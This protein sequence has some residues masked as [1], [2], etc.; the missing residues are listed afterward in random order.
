[1]RAPIIAAYDPFVEDRAPVELALAAGD[2]TGARVEVVSVLPPYLVE[3]WDEPNTA[4]VLIASALDRVRR[5][6]G[7][8]VPTTVGDLSVPH[9]LHA[10]AGREGA[11]LLVVGSTQRGHAGRVLPGST[12]ERLLHGATCAVALAPHGY[13]RKPIETVAVGFT[14]S[15][16]GH[17]AVRTAHAIARRAGARLRVVAALHVSGVTDVVTTPGMP[18]QR[19]IALEG[20]RRA[21]LSDALTAA[22]SGLAGVP[23]E[24]ELHVDDAADILLR[25]SEHVD[26][27]V[28]GSRGYG[29][30]RSVLLGGVSRRVV[31]RAQCPVVVLPRGVEQPLDGLLD[32]HGAATA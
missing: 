13:A 22:I 27:L 26:L 20:H 16:E 19:A 14:D 29:P 15:D 30:L 7:V 23:V 25:V 32:A 5:D 1:M 3:H 21:Q 11:A 24:P 6:L 8:E 28:C 18:A 2:F 9:A 10:K 4:R 31:D 17:A 12:A